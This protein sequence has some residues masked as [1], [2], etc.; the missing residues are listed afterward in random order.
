MG[1]AGK[2]FEAGRWQGNGRCPDKSR[3]LSHVST[4]AADCTTRFIH[5][6]CQLTVDA[7]AM[8]GKIA[9]GLK[10]SDSA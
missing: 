3:Y 4:A 10:S 6:T 9:S 7:Q 8:K 5:S 1:E 2:F